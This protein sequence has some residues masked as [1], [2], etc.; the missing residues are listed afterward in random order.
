MAEKT[1]VSYKDLLE[2]VVKYNTRLLQERRARIPYH[3]SSTNV[4]YHDGRRIYLPSER[5]QG[6]G[7][8]QIFTYPSRRWKLKP[9]PPAP[10]PPPPP[11]CPIPQ[12]PQS[13][14]FP[15]DPINQ[16]GLV[17]PAVGAVTPGVAIPNVCSVPLVEPNAATTASALRMF[18]DS[19]T[20]S[21]D[22]WS[23]QEACNPSETIVSG[24]GTESNEA[25]FDT[26]DDF[27]D[28]S[29]RRR[30]GSKPPSKVGLV[31]RISLV[32]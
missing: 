11:E 22:S 32:G 19:L 16:N 5:G 7:T 30:G 20:N 23:T 12:F 10:N 3:D 28:G 1:S 6:S 2:S 25:D 31:V 17:P 13:T 21:R 26:D 29:R 9:R 18:E 24:D 15:A 4:S 14:L 27:E 8:G